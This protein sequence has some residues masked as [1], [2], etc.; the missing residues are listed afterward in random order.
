MSDL[1]KEIEDTFKV[2]KENID[3]EVVKIIKKE[4]SVDI[5]KDS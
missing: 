3:R 4:K 5:G 1:K 2:E